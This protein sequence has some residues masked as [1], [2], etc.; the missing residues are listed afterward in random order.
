MNSYML[1]RN[2]YSIS[3]SIKFGLLLFFACYLSNSFSETASRNKQFEFVI[4]PNFSDVGTFSEGLASF[5]SNHKWGFIDKLGKVII[6]PQFNLWQAQFNTGFSDGLV[7]VNFNNGKEDKF[8]IDGNNVKNLKWGFA[9]KTG[10]L[11]IP[12]IFMGDYFSPPTFSEGLASVMSSSMFPESQL[13]I[14]VSAKYGYID[15]TGD[16][17]IKPLF[18]K[19]YEFNGGMAMVEVD[20]KQGFIDKKGNVVIP[21]IYDSLS[22]FSEGLAVAMLDKRYFFIDRNGNRIS[23]KTY[24]D[25]DSFSEGLA[26]FTVGDKFGFIDKNEKIVIKPKFSLGSF[27]SLFGA[28]G[29]SS[30]MHIVEFGIADP[31]N[32]LSSGKLGYID[33]TGNVVINPK[34]DSASQFKNG[35]AIVEL[36]KK[37]F[38]INV[39]G[40]RISA[41]YDSLDFEDNGLLKV[42]IGDIFNRKYGF[43]RH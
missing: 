37:Y 14:T 35:K 26:R 2:P 3:K 29:F 22:R 36:D 9:D 32:L 21:L 28:G 8:D 10:K 42:G 38:L 15:K 18:D 23:D 41:I 19:A 7:A 1:T 30:G 40:D 12:P 31:K 11:V 6:E 4:P 5:K 13:L 27:M 17:V 25:L 33:K 20:G 24:D 43:V 34:F 16:F 39:K